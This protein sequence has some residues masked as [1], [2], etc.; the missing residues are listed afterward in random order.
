MPRFLTIA[1]ILM[2]V[3]FAFI[4]CSQPT[5]SNKPPAASA[6]RPL[7]KLTS[8]M[9]RGLNEQAW[10]LSKDVLDLHGDDP[11]V[12]ARIA[13]LAYAI[14]KP[15]ETASLLVRACRAESYAKEARVQQALVSLIEVGRLYDAMDLLESAVAEHPDQVSSRR[16]L[17]E[18]AMNSE[19][20]ARA[21]PHG[22]ELVLSRNFD[23]SLLLMLGNTEKRSLDPVVLA[24]MSE[25]NESDR[26]PM[27]GIA[28]VKFDEG[29]TDAAIEM[30][31][32]IVDTHPQYLPA[33][34]LLGRSLALARRT[35][36]LVRWFDQ[37][38]EGIESQPGYWL[39]LGDWALAEGR[40]AEAARSYWESVRI[41][42]DSMEPWT[43]L[44]DALA[45]T[46]RL[47]PDLLPANS[48]KTIDSIRSRVANLSKLS[49]WKTRFERDGKQSREI[50]SEI[51]NALFDLGRPWEAEAWASV[52]TTF[53]ESDVAS[54][55]KSI[56]KLRSKIVSSLSRN[57]PWQ[58]TDPYPEMQLDLSQIS[59][60]TLASMNARSSQQASG[61]IASERAEPVVSAPGTSRVD[62]AL[63]KGW[64]LDDRAKELG[65][66][67]FG[68]TSDRLD[69]P[70]I[71]LHET[72]GCGG[73]TIDYDLDGWP[74]LYLMAAGGTPPWKDSAANAL[75][76]N[77]GGTF[78]DVTES[79]STG[80]QGF[81]QGVTVGDINED[82]FL[83]LLIL[84]YGPNTLLINNG[85][86]T[87]SD[88]TR[89]WNLNFDKDSMITWSTS[90]AIADIDGDG[91]SDVFIANYCQGLEPVTEVCS[92]GD[93]TVARSCSPVKFAS[94]GDWLLQGQADS[95]LVNQTENWGMDPDV[96]G[97]G[98]G[99]VVG[100]LDS[101]PGLEVFVVN[102]MTN[103]HC[104]TVAR[105]EPSSKMKVIESAMIRG[106]AT[107]GRSLSQGSMG[108]A[109]SDFDRDGDLDLYVTNFDKEYNT[110]HVQTSPGTWQDRTSLAKLARPT[111]SMVGFGTEAI[112]F[113]LDGW[114]ELIIA[115][116]HVDVF[117]RMGEPST[118]AQPMQIFKQRGSGVF[119]SVGSFVAGDYLR[120][121]HVGRG[122]WT[123]DSDRDGRLDVVVT[124]QT[125]PVALLQNRCPSVG[126]WI[127]I[128]LSG[129]GVSRDAIG[130]R[131]E[132]SIQTV[133][134]SP[135]AV[136]TLLAGDGYL[137]S[138]Q[139]GLRFAVPKNSQCS[140]SVH[141]PDGT[142]QSHDGLVP[143]NGFLVIQ[144]D[145]EVFRR[146]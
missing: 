78:S 127:E 52:A 84:N 16:T 138:N 56:E 36:E 121:F 145:P 53:P 17:F 118:Y 66:D 76:R 43:K 65:I 55:N 75:F 30:L 95:R 115:N 80:D 37:V 9:N 68:R 19:E 102:D 10:V 119:D 39:A 59:F 113:D 24:S 44:G 64:Q 133:K 114:S 12:I 117:S 1:A 88:Q 58:L 8:L 40:N 74:D 142:H 31:K 116:G 6:E 124:H 13:K 85:D 83:D 49:Q 92:S 109:A 112:D 4:G 22:R 5:S 25:R 140:I 29:D 2:V 97:R 132:L 98:L 126:G 51:V 42:P 101:E 96:P 94:H 33:Q 104:W 105:D 141:W 26:R 3:A 60:P 134:K 107:D 18:L 70:G 90:A 15:D 143:G 23:L 73:G 91:L 21:L 137:S 38:P 146:R 57:T 123:I 50:T 86:G 46:R 81:G 32:S 139:R 20:R 144:S 129:V 110:L 120:R 93:A 82:G 54:G 41:D 11:E 62:E 103:N 72:L 136:A 122:L 35:N 100:A 47:T 108:I 71:K 45:E 7:R 69:Q 67:F 48:L 135:Y 130:T 27:I 61:G 131:V 63:I 128:G 87:F 77:L 99:V 89:A 14:G 125:E 79:S 106:I 34:V 28:K 111:L